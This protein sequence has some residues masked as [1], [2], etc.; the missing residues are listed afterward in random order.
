MCN[1]KPQPVGA[2]NK[3]TPASVK[4]MI[5]CSIF[6]ALT[7]V[8]AQIAVPLPFTPIPLHLAMLPVILAGGM[9]GSKLG[10]RSQLVYLGLGCLGVPI[11]AGMQ[12]GLGVLLGPTGGFL[13][14]YLPAAWI[15]GRFY[16]RS[17]RFHQKKGF[18]MW[19]QTGIFILAL[20]SC[21]ALGVLWYMAVTGVGWTAAFAS[22]ILP[23]LPGDI[24]KSVVA[25]FLLRRVGKMSFV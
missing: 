3:N 5:L 24:L 8:C 15:S 14:G 25:V 23:F 10:L 16:Q 1:N 13:M 21:Y 11:F 17:G 12:G 22:C 19:Y 20:F 7:A 4:N 2:G 6:A 9:L 18:S